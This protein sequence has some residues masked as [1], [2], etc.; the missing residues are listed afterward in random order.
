MGRKCLIYKGGKV[1]QPLTDMF[2]YVDLTPAAS[3]NVEKFE[4][5]LLQTG[6]AA[7]HLDRDWETL[8]THWL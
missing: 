5:K 6:I 1:D 3:R 2:E 8:S 4:T 7:P